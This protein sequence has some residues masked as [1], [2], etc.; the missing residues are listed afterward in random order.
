M[1]LFL[2]R[3]KQLREDRYEATEVYMASS[4][5]ELDPSREVD[6]NILAG[7]IR[8]RERHPDTHNYTEDGIFHINRDRQEIAQE[9][10][11]IYDEHAADME[12]L[13]EFK[14]KGLGPGYADEYD[15]REYM[16]FFPRGASPIANDMRH[17]HMFNEL[18]NIL[19]E[20]GIKDRIDNQEMDM[21]KGTIKKWQVLDD[22]GFAKDQI[23]KVQSAIKAPISD[24]LERYRDENNVKLPMPINNANASQWRDKKRAIDSADFNAKLIEFEHKRHENYFLKRY[25]RPKEISH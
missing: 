18:E 22:Q 19:E 25:E 5:K 1:T 12:Y 21:Y 20:V 4:K 8:N 9:L 11:G 17:Q 15:D 7:P 6:Q 16:L 24:E 10:Q 3:P 23:D 14:V 13:K 2:F